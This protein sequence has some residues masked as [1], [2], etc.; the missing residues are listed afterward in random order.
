[1]AIHIH[2]SHEVYLQG[3]EL[4]LQIGPMTIYNKPL[5]N[6]VHDQFRSL[7][8][9]INYP[10]EPRPKIAR[11]DLL[12]ENLGRLINIV[13]LIEKDTHDDFLIKIVCE[14]MKNIK[15]GYVKN[16]RI[17][18][19]KAENYR[20]TL[21]TSYNYA[22]EK[23]HAIAQTSMVNLAGVQMCHERLMIPVLP[24]DTSKPQL[25]VSSARSE[26]LSTTMDVQQNI[27]YA[28]LKHTS[29]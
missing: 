10:K 17:K 6:L 22:L 16:G 1:M 2:S 18:D 11:E 3:A 27:F 20:Q 21:L 4:F 7:L 9:F 26:E 13:T 28:N 15:M 25:L 8:N 23:G 29:D 24:K 19:I 12:P 14:E 5:E